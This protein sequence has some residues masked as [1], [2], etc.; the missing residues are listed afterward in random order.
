[1]AI[2]LQSTHFTQT[3]AR[4]ILR[5][6]SWKL[7][8]NLPPASKYVLVGAPHTSG[9]DLWHAL[10]IAHGAGIKIHWVGKD[11]L[12]RQPLGAFMRWLGGIPVARHTRSNFVEQI[13]AAFNRVEQ[14]VL[15]IA[16]EGTRKVAG[17]WRTGFYYIAAGARVPIA[18]GYV[19]YRTR[20]LGIGDH[21][22]PSGD[23]Q[24]DFARIRQ[25]YTG[26]VGRRP[27]RQGQI[28]LLPPETSD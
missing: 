14:M 24:A 8:T 26:K 21:F 15:A 22:M 19:D 7:E 23:I 3:L 25:F 4:T 18:L 12:F 27:E 9:W 6:T 28:T 17:H 11:S 20:T 16:P 2:S 1:M 10:L 5:L 13:I